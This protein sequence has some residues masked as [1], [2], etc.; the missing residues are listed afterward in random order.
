MLGPVDGVSVPDLRLGDRFVD[1]M[2]GFGP[3]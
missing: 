3:D 2:Y 1:R